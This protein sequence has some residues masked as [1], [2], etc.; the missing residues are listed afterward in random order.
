MKKNFLIVVFIIFT[1]YSWGQS[2]NLI[3]NT[4]S[5]KNSKT[6]YIGV[7]NELFINSENPINIQ[8][9]IGVTLEQNKLTVRPTSIGK[10][11]IVFLSDKS[12]IPMT[13][14]VTRIPDPIPVIGGQENRQICKDVLLADN[15]ISLKTNNDNS[16]F[17]NYDIISFSVKFKD[18]I[19]DIKGNKFSTDILREL[20]S[21]KTDDTFT[22]ASLVGRNKEINKTINLNSNYSYKIK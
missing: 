11:T 2:I 13:F 20:D 16:F 10:L 5:N 18:K 1:Q 3:N 4:V 8:P 19:F 17:A 21:A 6:L 9:Q 22:I 15:S 7:E 14:N 12:K